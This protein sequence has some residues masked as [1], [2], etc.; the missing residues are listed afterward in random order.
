MKKALLI[1]FSAIVFVLASCASAAKLLQDKTFT[2]TELNG[3]EYVSMGEEPA[4]ISFANGLCNAN[5]GGN[6][7]NANYEETAKCELKLSYGLSTKMLVPEEY[8]ED[9]FI[10]ALNTVVKFE[11]NE[12]VLSLLDEAGVAVIKAKLAE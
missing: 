11:L 7:I 5:L 9:E 10:R 8:R 2:I 6:I 4:A 3:I 12:N 1:A